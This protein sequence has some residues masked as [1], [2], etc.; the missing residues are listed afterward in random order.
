MI[1][2]HKLNGDEFVLN[3]NHIEVIEE[4]PDT[5]ITLGNE[6]KYIVKEKKEKVINLAIEYLNNIHSYEKCKK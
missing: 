5:V 6:K 2:L 1:I 3:V 4:T